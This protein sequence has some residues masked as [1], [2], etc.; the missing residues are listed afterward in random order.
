MDA[1]H[2]SLCDILSLSSKSRDKDSPHRLPKNLLQMCIR[3]V[4]LNLRDYTKLTIPLLR[5]LSRLL[6]LLSSWFSKTL[7]EKLLEH[8]Q[9]WTDPEKIM[10]LNIWKK[11]EEPLV[12]ASIIGLFELL[13]DD[14]HFVELLV[15]T[16]LKLENALP[17]YKYCCLDESPFRLPLAKYLNKHE[18]ATASFFVND[19]RLKNPIYSDLLQDII[20][21]PE[22]SALRKKLSDNKWSTMLLNVCFE[23]P[24]AIIRAEKGG[25]T[26]ASRSHQPTNSPRNAADILSMHGINIDL[27]GHGQKCAALKQ[28]LEHKKEKLQSAKKDETKAKDKI[29]KVKKAEASATPEK[30]DRIKKNMNA[31]QRQLDKAQEHLSKIT[32]EVENAQ[33]EYNSELAKTTKE[34]ESADT[35]QSPRSMTFE[36]LELQHQGFC[37]VETLIENDSTYVSEHTDVVRAFRWLWRSK[38]RHFRLFHED[39]MPPR[40]NGESIVL[41]RFLVNFAKTSNDVDILFD[42]LRIFLQPTSSDFSF[43]QD[44]LK[45]TVC[46]VLSLEQK[47]RVIQRFFPVIASEGIEELKV[48]SIQFLILPMLKNDLERS[49]EFKNRE[50]DAKLDLEKNDSNPAANVAVTPD[51]KVPLHSSIGISESES[52]TC[53]QITPAVQ[54]TMDRPETKHN[55]S[56]VSV[57]DS[58]LTSTFIKEVLLH[59]GKSRSFGSRLNI[60]LLRLSS[61]FLEFMGD[62]LQDQHRQEIIKF[63]WGLLRQDDLKTK[64]WACISICHY[65]ASFPTPPKNILQIYATI[66]R[67]HH[68]EAKE[69]AYI[70]MDLL[71]PSLSKSLSMDYYA[72]I[73]QYTIKILY[74]EGNSI[75]SLS[76]VCH[77]IVRHEATFYS[78]RD[79]IIPHLVV[80]LN[81]IGLPINSSVENRVLSI[82]MVDMLLR[83][84]VSMSS[85]DPCFESKSMGDNTN[86][87]D[88][89]FDEFPRLASPE[90][91]PIKAIHR[92]PK[93]LHEGDEGSKSCYTIRKPEL[94]TIVNFL[95]RLILLVSASDKEDQLE[96][97]IDAQLLLKRMLQ[98]WPDI[99]ICSVYFDRV[100]SLCIEERKDNMRKADDD[101]KLVGDDK[102]SKTTNKTAA[103][104]GQ[105][106]GRNKGDVSQ[107]ISASLL[108]AFL[109]IFSNILEFA[110]GNR[111]LHN[112]QEKCCNILLVC[113]DHSR[114]SKHKGLRGQLK[115][116][117]HLLFERPDS[118][119]FTQE[120][121]ASYLEANLLDIFGL[122]N[123]KRLPKEDGG[124]SYDSALFFL[125]MIEEISLLRPNIPNL[126]SN[127]LVNVTGALSKSLLTTGSSKRTT[128]SSTTPF[129]SPSVAIFDE[130]FVANQM[131][132]KDEV[133]RKK[134]N[135]PTEYDEESTEVHCLIYCLRL[136]GRSL[137]AHYF[138]KQRHKFINI[139]SNILDFGSNIRLLLA[140]TVLI[141]TWFSSE[142][143]VFSFQETLNFVTKLTA[144]EFH[145]LP[146]IE[147][148]P[149]FHAVSLAVL[150][151]H[152]RYFIKAD[153]EKR[154]ILEQTL[155]GCVLVT[156]RRIRELVLH[157]IFSHFNYDFTKGPI[158]LEYGLSDLQGESNAC[159]PVAWDSRPMDVLDKLIN[160]PFDGL[161]SRLW[162]FAFVDI[163][164]ASSKGANGIILNSFKHES[165]TNST[166]KLNPTVGTVQS[167]FEKI[168]HDRSKYDGIVDRCKPFWHTM[169]DVD[170]N[171]NCGD[172][173]H[174]TRILASC[175]TKLCQELLESLI[176]RVWESSNNKERLSMIPSLEKLLTQPSHAQF[177]KNSVVRMDPE[178]LRYREINSIQ[179]MLRVV[180]KLN[181]TPM[182]SVDAMLYLAKH[183]NCWHEV[184]R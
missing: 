153:T 141:G 32:K 164:L 26:A 118:L 138:T 101:R 73:F 108:S 135:V 150:N 12:A 10:S 184:R 4:L 123:H 137:V 122:K 7:G 152:K 117:L 147:S 84:E 155:V 56:H 95:L 59:G 46:N 160:M 78:H 94:E 174:A 120:T 6:S 100:E 116:F 64:Q 16:T 82:S 2:A 109:Q 50:K 113:F 157:T 58:E 1:A 144:L 25:S 42:L 17:R 110:P 136:V 154:L 114:D 19:H 107:P 22:S 176:S 36:A 121:C 93:Q 170:T 132:I 151:V 106:A 175:D 162:T 81:K 79:Q 96:L 133:G 129:A 23:R 51:T 44:F 74:E 165:K 70:A 45:D 104:K 158:E 11:G 90:T 24:L 28:I 179:M 127:T 40:F 8:L 35:R 80:A 61:L 39:S 171:S 85:Q 71:I 166:E 159:R 177:L 126:L 180:G 88:T 49:L 68:Q 65:I 115:R 31:A 15:K 63:A 130:I 48:L 67:C 167:S 182:I 103:E 30:A 5:G 102:K 125:K 128:A 37:L 131:K 91:S 145:G 97:A 55:S 47:R 124:V 163:L 76:H 38:G 149:L 54:G 83:W 20:K 69:L 52:E 53:A 146:E 119:E 140:T 34:S 86:V 60:E 99:E 112:T 27:T 87:T 111:F 92:M 183:Y 139:L 178:T 9:R 173:L 143:S 148:Q 13:P 75:Q 181:P 89:V 161:G 172:L 77:I 98:K 43:V 168:F 142:K 169:Y 18:E 156:N 57:L 41:A 105:S 134:D 3:P 66:L 29:E 33:K 21:R 62:I 14:S 72:N